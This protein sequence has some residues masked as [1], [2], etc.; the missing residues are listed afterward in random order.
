MSNR[1]GE[2]DRFAINCALRAAWTTELWIP[3][4]P[5]YSFTDY[6][7]AAAARNIGLLHGFE[8]L[9][10]DMERRGI[11]PQE[12]CDQARLVTDGGR[13]SKKEAA[14]RG[15]CY[16]TN[17]GCENDAEVLLHGRFPLCEEHYRQVVEA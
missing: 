12:G 7:E 6:F 17:D 11:L 4:D 13:V 10:E 14:E 16:Y 5:D 8:E 1:A 15:I 9:A 3:A 2:M